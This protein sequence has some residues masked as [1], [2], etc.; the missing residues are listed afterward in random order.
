MHIPKRLL[1]FDDLHLVSDGERTGMPFPMNIFW[2]EMAQYFQVVN[3]CS[4]TLYVD[5]AELEKTA[6]LL[7][8]NRLRFIHRSYFNSP[9]YFFKRFWK[10]VPVSL[11]IIWKA[12]RHS[13]VVF[14]RMP[15]VWSPLVYWIAKKQ[16]K[17]VIGHIKGSWVGTVEQKGKGNRGITSRVERKIVSFYE[18][19]HASLA[20]K[21]PCLVMSNEELDL[22]RTVNQKVDRAEVSLVSSAD[23]FYR[24]DT[25]TD[26]IIKLLF[27]GRLSEAKG[28][29]H[30]LT[31]MTKLD[32]NLYKLY[33]VGDGPL[34]NSIESFIETNKIKNINMKGSLSLRDGLDKLFRSCDIFVLPSLAE[35]FPKVLY[36]APARGLP[37]ITTSVGAIAEK[38]SDHQEAILIKPADPDDI[39]NA[40]KLVTKDSVLRRNLIVNGYKFVEKHTLEGTAKKMALFLSN[41]SS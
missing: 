34:T 38:M 14:L 36:E 15:S 6:V 31:A 1:I 8:S 30:L 39:V 12:I 17:C 9:G 11:P 27:V 26:E 21:I 40:V 10:I 3:L 2:H 7:D 37:I 28:L 22:Y 16:G 18:N 20:K 13:D 23:F 32:P 4:P 19:F 5:Q 25:C 35:G 29:N 33:I 24:T 41:N